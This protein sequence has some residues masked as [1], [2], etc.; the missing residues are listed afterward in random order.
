MKTYK[1]TYDVQLKPAPGSWCTSPMEILRQ[2]DEVQKKT[3]RALR[4]FITQEKIDAEVKSIVPLNGEIGI[5][6]HCSDAA[7]EKIRKQPFVKEMMLYSVQ[8]KPR[9]QGFKF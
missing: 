3:L 7:A 6:L 5:V 1:I 9:A 2:M 8:P 4:D